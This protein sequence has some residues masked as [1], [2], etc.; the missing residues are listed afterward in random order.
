MLLR[1]LLFILLCNSANLVSAQQT[2][3]I[4]TGERCFTGG[5]ILFDED[6]FMGLFGQGRNLD[7]DYTGGLGF[8]ASGAFVEKSWINLLERATNRF[9]TLDRVHNSN[10]F[11]FHSMRIG[12]T[13][14]SPRGVDLKVTTPIT[15]DRPYACIAMLTTTHTSIDNL[16]ENALT[17]EFGIGSFGSMIGRDVQT[18]V[19]GLTRTCDTCRPYDPLGWHNQISDG[20]EITAQYNV[21]FKKLITVDNKIRNASSP[22]VLYDVFLS[23]DINVGHFTA[24]GSTIT[25]RFG[26]IRS[27]WAVFNSSPFGPQSQASGDDNAK[28]RNSELY[29]FGSIRPK[30]ILYNAALQ[31]Q[32]KSSAHTFRS[33]QVNHLGLQLDA[34]VSATFGCFFTLTAAYTYRTAEFKSSKARPHEWIGIYLSAHCPFYRK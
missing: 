26:I 10:A 30:G 1:S 19:H 23:R 21:S 32:T 3:N 9:F 13:A 16:R 4:K 12:F 28:I 25:G 11:H 15:D 33:N 7:R 18:W 24:I 6:F 31:G 29:L 14:F 20:G 17:T 5:S 27:N 34:G 22:W 2:I 8:T